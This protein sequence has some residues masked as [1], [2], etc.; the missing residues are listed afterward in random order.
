MNPRPDRVRVLLESGE[1]LHGLIALRSIGA[2]GFDQR[3]FDAI[4]ASK[5]LALVL[6]GVY[7]IVGAPRTLAQ[8]NLAAVL[9]AGGDALLT[10]HAAAH[11][12]RIATDLPRELHVLTHYGS[13]NRTA[14]LDAPDQYPLERIPF[15]M[16]RTLRLDI[17]DRIVA[18]GIPCTTAARTLIELAGHLDVGRLESMFENARRLRLISPEHLGVRIG[19][20]GGRGVAG[21]EKIRQIVERQS[22]LA[23]T[24]SDLELRLWN[25]MSRRSFARAK[26][27]ERQCAAIRSDGQTARIDVA[28]NALRYGVEAEGWEWHQGRVRWKRD[29]RRVATLETA[30]WRLTFVTWEDV[31]DHPTETLQRIE[32]A[33]RERRRLVH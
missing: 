32:A 17:A 13:N 12:L 33:Y 6:P 11:L 9:S 19:Q 30:G 4:V 29:K 10:G 22:G 1:A 3:E 7:R 27:P 2:F 20:L 26:P 21:S 31:V 16:R 18:D 25:L 5:R 8:L 14:L 15:R 28:W 24:E 23:P